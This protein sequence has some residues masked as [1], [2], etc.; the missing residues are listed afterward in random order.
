MDFVTRHASSASGNQP[1]SSEPSSAPH[2]V[3]ELE[4][5]ARYM[6]VKHS[7]RGR[8]KR[9]LCISNVA[10]ITLDPSTLSVTNSYDV[11]SDFESAGP[12]LGRDENSQ[13]FTVSV[14]T[15]GRGKF[16]A[17]KFSSKF[18]ASILTELHYIRWSRIAAVA[19]FPVLHLRRRTLEWIPLKL[20]V[21]AVGVELLQAQSGTLRW[22]LDF[23]D[24]GSPAIILLYDAY[25]KKNIEHAGFVLCPLYGRKSKAFQAASGTTNTA[26]ISNL[27]KTAKHM[28]G[29]SLS[30]DNSQSLTA[31]EYIK[32]RAKEAV[33]AEETPC[34]EWSVTRLRSTAHGTAHVLGLSSGIG[35][36]GGLGEHG[37]AVSRQ[38]ILTK[39][40]LVERRPENYEA[41][42]VRPLSAVSS[43]VRFAEEPQMFA[44]EFDDGCPI[45][46]Y[47]STSRDS[48]LAAVRDVLQTEGQ[49]PVPVLPRLTM[50]GHR[51]D[52]PCGRVYLQVQQFPVGVQIPV[53]DMESASMHL[54]HL[55]AAAKDAV[56][57]G[58]SIPGSRAKLWRRIREFN[59]CIPYSGVPPNIEVPEVTLMA[60]ITMLPAAPNLPPESPPPPPP[61]PKAASTVMGF[62]AC[63]RR[64]L[65][66]RSAASHVM[67]FP[68]AVGR[69]MGLLRN[70]SEGIAAEAAGLV[71]VL[72]GGG[73]GDTHILMDSKG[74]QHATFMHTKSVLFAHQNYVTILV[75]RLKPMSVSPLLSMSLVEV[76][77]AML[78][79]PHGETTQYTTFVELLRQVAGLR[80]R[81]FALF[82]HPAESVRE[83]VA[84]IMRT[85]AEEDAIAAE[86]MRDAALRD[87]ALL[88]HLLHAFFL[89]GERREV[90]RQLVALWADSYQP[91]LDLLSRVLPPGLVAYLH[92][93]SDSIL[94][95]D[96]QNFLNQEGPLT[97]RRQRRILQQRKGRTVRGITSQEHALPSVNSVEIGDSSNQLSSGAYNRPDLDPSSGQVPDFH[98]SVHTVGNLTSGSS[99]AGVL[100]TDY[101]AA[102]AS[103]DTPSPSISPALDSN[104]IDL[105]DSDAN[106]VGFSNSGLPAPAQV[107]VENTPVGSGRLLCNWPEFWRAFSLD[108][109]RADLIWNERTRQELREALQAEVHK[110]DVEKE[111]TEDI[112]PGGAT[113]EVLDGKNSVPQISWNYTEFYVSYH[114]LS[115]EVCVGQYYLRLL[116]ESGSS[117]R[118]QDFPLRDPVVF[119]RALYHRFLCDADTG[120]TV[121]G[122]VPDELGSS[123]DWCDMGRLDGFG[124]GG[125]SSVRELCARAMA[126]VYEQ[127]YKTIGPFDG[128]AHIT[129]LLD[130]TDD[131]ALRHRL[132]LLLKVLMKVLSNVE[133][134]VLVGGCVL[135]VDFLTVA[136][137]A[138]ERTS[139]PLQSNLI[140]A[141]AFMEPLKEWMFID[142]DGVQVGPM[143]KDA[144]R[145]FWSKKAIDWTTR[146]W[147]SGMFDWKRFRDIRELR[148]ALAV[149]VP[150][151]TSTQ[152][153]EAALSILHSMVSAHSDLDDAGEIVTPT[154]RVKWIL[155]SPRCVPH[156]A[157]A[158]LTGEPNIVEGAAALLKAIVTRN[159]KAMIRLYSTGAFYFALAYPGSNL[160]SI[161]Q[162]FSVT[163]VHQAFHGGEEAAVSSSLPLA[164][165]SVLG[166]LLPESLLY[167]LERSGPVA[168]SAAMVSDSDTPEIIWTHKMRA[169]HLIRQHA[170]LIQ[171]GH[172]VLQ[173]LG[174]FPQKLSQHC[175]SLYDY[176]PMPP[177]TYPE[178]RD[179]MWCHRYYLRNLCDEIRFPKWPIV[180]HVEFLQSLLAMWR[181]EL[182][183]RPMDLSEE[184]A[185]KILEI[186]LED[187]SSEGADKRHVEIDENISSTS[188]HIEN[189]DEEKLKR[190]YR[191]L[192]IRYHPDK[193][194]EGREKFLAVQKAYERLQ[195]TMQGL[196][197]PQLWRLLLLLKGQCILYRRYGDV[198]EPFKYAGYPML[199]NAVTVDKDDNNFLS[200]DRVPLLVAAS[201]LIWLTCASSSLNGEELVRDGGIPLLATLLSRCMCV[202]QPTTPASEPSAIIVT[203]VMRTFSVLSRFESAR[204]EVL[205]LSGLV[206]DIVHSTE[207]ELVPATVDASLQTVAHVSVSSEL[208]DALLKAGALWYLLPLLLQYDSTA[209]EADMTEA[210]GVGSIV[211]VAKNMHAVQAFHALSRLSGLCTDGVSTP[212]NQAAADALRAL[213]TPKLANMLKHQLPTDLLSSLNTNLESPEIIWN[214]STRA[215]LLKFVDQQRACQGPDG[216]YDLKESHGFKYQVL[217]KELHVGNVYLRVYNDQPESEISEPEAFCVALIDFISDI[218]HNRS[219]TDSKI[220][221]KPNL[222]GSSSEPELQ[223]GT[224]DVPVTEEG[225]RDD[226]AAVSNVE[227]TCKGDLE[228]FKNLQIGL[229]SLQNLLTSNPNLAAIFSTKEQLVPLFDCFSVPVELDSNIPQ[230]CLSVLSLLTMYAPCLEAMVADGTSLL[231]LL[232]MLHCSPNCREGALHVL[233]ALASTHELAWAAAKHGGVVYI[234]ELLLPLQEEIHLPQRAAAASLLGKLVGQ[235]MH[236]PRVAIT[237]ARFFPDGL[238]SA[239]RDGPGEAVIAALEQTTE[240]PELVWTPA[241]AASLSAQIATMASDLYREQMKGRVIDWDVPEQASGQQEMRDEPQVGGIYVRL[242]LKDPK[243]PLR[244]PKRFLEGLLDQY[245][246][247][248]AAT[249]Y[250]MQGVDTELPLLLS[251][252][253][254]SLLR[255]HPALADHVGYLGYVPK[256]VAAMAYEGRR[257][258]M[259]SGEMKNGNHVDEIYETEDGQMQPSTQTPQ[260]R[261]RLSCL[262]VLHQ[263]A[264]STTCA[265]AMAATSVGTPQVVPLLMKAIGWQGG[266]ILALETLKR[267]VVAGNRARDALVAQGLKVGLVEILLGL[268]DWRAGGRN[269]LCSQMKWNESEASIGRVLAIEVLHA[270]A[271]EG[272][273]CTKVRDI[274]NSSDVWG[275]YKDQKHDLFLPSNAQSSAAGIAGLIE[276]SSS[277]F[278]YALPAPPPKPAMNFEPYGE[279]GLRVISIGAFDWDLSSRIGL[280]LHSC[281]FGV[282][283]PASLLLGP[284][285][286]SGEGTA[287]PH[288]SDVASPGLC[289]R[290]EARVSSI[291]VPPPL[292]IENK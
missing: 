242:F 104:A 65:A 45:H 51:I 15:D 241:M 133:A 276:N 41:V 25:G 32:R 94:P 183:R 123:D 211:Q 77:E 73:P 132:L 74:E 285:I 155:S 78:C 126:I 227:V 115:K 218:V 180:E 190:Q 148:W 178:L 166:G 56:A 26:I 210:H 269:G 225:V 95:E 229:T 81:L 107:V 12:I 90:S 152:V 209:K 244:N 282:A 6:V 223:N 87:G 29:L 31:A 52:P 247:S 160:L 103:S 38:L 142:K 9:I 158:F 122:T 13:E 40:S 262:R 76:L 200:S 145:R 264:A 186:S 33:G 273:H 136:H 236:G 256:L 169:E 70:G 53:A 135:A 147:A 216:S 275:A 199:L 212:Y 193:N 60:L 66:S 82:G 62:I 263:L 67:S 168:F 234:L 255:V 14:R 8:Y 61:S 237:L 292:V 214:S 34:G 230:L 128:T 279:G 219:A 175:H 130:R 260:E 43:L 177:V 129:V 100:Q 164:K 114:S 161:A 213:L 179:E 96:A 118:A 108:H 290:I 251:A 109:N 291:V 201:E 150:V 162:L 266:S 280:Q 176:A 188:K 240:T 59:A 42:I 222:N 83:T 39:A 91:A 35:T 21:T 120:L 184:E 140:A 88:R 127:H 117:G 217:S 50:P 63:L 233:Y 46:V 159:P 111:R 203:N 28:V 97:R 238:V 92:T 57:E 138:S 287:M 22:S 137:E 84:V 16:K 258:T 89:V 189:I 119:F 172:Q 171:S 106:M 4:Y 195:A 54:K 185:C 249:H 113:I 149:R 98:S 281:A 125:G 144:I 181:E 121:D 30:V 248:I 253:L 112:V 102:V 192:A 47:A 141:T 187:V 80:R 288:C 232:Q 231:L 49:C 7:W 163:H 1:Q 205:K 250:D 259:A 226:S 20:K 68:A 85:I 75:N 270:F 139:I 2:P 36:K 24:M 37:D 173:H 267:V 55:A 110:L 44:I 289:K 283:Q 19:E 23:R 3:E 243:F 79:E 27:T 5:L 221:N 261:V 208:Q 156:V 153:G 202:V 48:L 10:I 86:S 268:L 101:S 206:D 134:C 18:R 277:R 272:A 284:G 196:Q 191:K 246:S 165:R 71:A 146:C 265:E 245:V 154:P 278:A 116:L 271:T 151:L 257:E 207:L 72:I 124:G 17:M 64:L 252:A 170:I 11:S 224:A 182:T 58:G 167:V 157:Q 239:I 274:L 99:S 254:V 235:P 220:Q 131:R 105:V 204:S 198:L 228:L 215:E 143:E 197:G 286:V 93:R 194:P 69:I 174:D